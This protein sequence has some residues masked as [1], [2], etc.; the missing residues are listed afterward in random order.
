MNLIFHADDYGI[1]EK[2]AADVR[3]CAA[4][5]C[6]NSVSLMPNSPVLP[7]TAEALLREL[8]DVK[9]SVHLNL[10]EGRC[11][12]DPS[13]IPL[14]V[15]ERGCFRLSY[16]TMLLKSVLPGH[17]ALKRQ[18]EAELSAQIARVRGVLPE[19]RP[20]RLD[21]HQHFHAIPLVFSAMMNVAERENLPVEFIRMP[22]EPILPFLQTPAA[23]RHIRPVNYIKVFLLKFLLLFD[24]PRFRKTGIRTAVFCGVA[25]SG[26]MN[27]RDVAQLLPA[28]ARYAGKRGADL[29]L[30]FHPGMPDGL[31]ECL[32][33]QKKDFVAF[34]LSDKRR[35]EFDALHTLPETIRELTERGVFH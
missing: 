9:T 28:L 11:V 19:G 34:N 31:K 10:V 13:K 30:L 24:R 8:P 33:T 6:L 26:D 12:S 14:L 5:G 2:Q 16:G 7:E 20:L 29:E 21:S 15:D 17:S 18:I 22:D 4:N 23:R 27:A 25:L 35:A 3:D 1:S 32:D